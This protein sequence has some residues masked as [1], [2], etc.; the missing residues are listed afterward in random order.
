[1]QRRFIYLVELGIAL[2]IALAFVSGWLAANYY[3]AANPP[4]FE[5]LDDFGEKGA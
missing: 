1:L 5:I 2:A 4:S 3:T